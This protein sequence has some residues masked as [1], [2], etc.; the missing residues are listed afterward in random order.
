M[1]KEQRVSRV[2]NL[3]AGYFGM[4]LGIIGMGFAWRY[5][6]TIW[7]VSR[8]VGDGLVVTATVIWALL[9]LAFLPAQPGGVD[10]SFSD[11]PPPAG[12]LLFDLTPP[13]PEE[14][15]PRPK[16]PPILR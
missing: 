4:V 8:I 9:A 15:A 7:P 11:A 6:S 10:I 5:A 13:A 14:P 16:G 3:P 1:N 2:L 12:A